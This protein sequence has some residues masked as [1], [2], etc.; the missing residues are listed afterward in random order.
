VAA[1]TGNTST[2]QGLSR[3]HETRTLAPEAARFYSA[4]E[5]GFAVLGI[6]LF[7]GAL[8]PLLRVPSGVGV[9]IPEGD[10]VLWIMWLGLYGVSS[11]LI[12]VRWRRFIYV[13]TRDKLLLLLIGIAM[14]SV[15]WSFA[16][17]ITLRREVALIGTT[18]FG[19]YLATRYTL[20]ELL[21]LLAWALGIAALLS[22]IFALM[23][24]SYGIMSGAYAS[25]S[26]QGVFAGGK[27]VLGRTMALS[28]IVFVLLALSTRKH[29]LV[30]W[31]GFVLSTGLLWMS[32]SVT[33][34]I[35]LFTVLLL[36]PLY[37]ALR[38]RYILFASLLILAVVVGGIAVTWLLANAED[39]LGVLGRDPTLTNRTELWPAVIE[40]IRQH[41]WLGYGYGAFWLGW[42]GE[43]AHVSLW[44]VLANGAALYPPYLHAHNG[45]LDLW[46][47]LGVLGL[48]TFALGFSLAALRAV[49][50]VRATKTATGLWPLV[51]LTFI[52]LYNFT[53]S[54][55]LAHNNVF[56][57]LYVTLMMLMAARS[58][59][60][61]RMTGRM[62]PPLG[63]SRRRQAPA[64]S[65][66]G[67]V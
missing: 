8:V 63:D 36:L 23:L 5:R 59:H 24:P 3:R 1:H 44:A 21:R 32:D 17:Q 6:F 52:F 12:L 20:D 18:L 57:V 33:S 49:S 56:W 64:F 11:L 50:W 45:F 47:D 2:A 55:I 10:P 26:W 31:S 37:Q 66:G 38:W 34:L 41:P 28:A 54:S 19:A 53:E 46:L 43:S 40:M 39:V 62:R 30:L 4:C 9:Q 58:P 61:I 65:E 60:P 35:S 29:R 51:F 27:N 25:E 15:L 7:S 42:S 13:A 22:L 14:L 16:P 48:A 67:D